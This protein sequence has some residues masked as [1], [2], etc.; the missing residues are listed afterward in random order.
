MSTQ[1]ASSVGTLQ[2]HPTMCITQSAIAVASHH[3]R[4][5]EQKCK[6]IA[7]GRWTCARGNIQALT[8]VWWR[9]TFPGRPCCSRQ[10]ITY[11]QY[12]Q[13]TF[14][15]IVYI[16]C[17]QTNMPPLKHVASANARQFQVP[18]YNYRY[19]MHVSPHTPR[20][21]KL[22]IHAYVQQGQKRPIEKAVLQWH[23]S[24]AG[25]H[26]RTLAISRC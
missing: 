13:S 21:C 10:C 11:V 9:Y 5:H 6:H 2:T 17:Q 12:T 26:S 16:I 4:R 25:F 18:A 8:V 1:Q 3:V 24:V 22:E 14:L 20:L 19:I 23:S 15:C 7:E